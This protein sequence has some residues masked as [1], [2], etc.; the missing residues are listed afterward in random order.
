MPSPDPP[1]ANRVKPARLTAGQQHAAQ[2]GPE[3]R[4]LHRRANVV[5]DV[6]GRGVG[7]LR[8]QT[9]LLDRGSRRRRH[10]R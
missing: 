2:D 8:R 9:T 4:R 3:R 6:T 7:L 1:A 5:R 10:P